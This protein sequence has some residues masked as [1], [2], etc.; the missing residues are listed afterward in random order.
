ML[1]QAVVGIDSVSAE[2]KC[3]AID[4]TVNPVNKKM[5]L[6]TVTRIFIKAFGIEWNVDTGHSNS[7]VASFDWQGEAT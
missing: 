2:G 1:D 3:L 7:F 6:A 4:N 5:Y